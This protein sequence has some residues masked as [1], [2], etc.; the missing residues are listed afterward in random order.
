MVSLSAA[1]IVAALYTFADMADDVTNHDLKA[2][3]DDL[4]YIV[5]RYGTALIESVAEWLVYVRPASIPWLLAAI[6]IG[7]DRSP[8]ADRFAWCQE[9]SL[10][11][12]R[13]EAA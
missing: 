12:L 4:F 13:G 7:P 10:L 11:L 1:E 2:V 6:G 5:A 9:Q 8:S 3:R